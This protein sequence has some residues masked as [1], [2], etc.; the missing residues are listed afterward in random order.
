[1]A[2]DQVPIG[3]G[4]VKDIEEKKTIYT[5]QIFKNPLVDTLVTLAGLAIAGAILY[6]VWSYLIG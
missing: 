4:Y 1:M 3:S 6:K 2:C 5:N